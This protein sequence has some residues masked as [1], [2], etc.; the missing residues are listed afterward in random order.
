MLDLHECHCTYMNDQLRVTS[1]V[2][3]I[4]LP[5]IRQTL[6]I[7]LAQIKQTSGAQYFVL[8]LALHLI[9][10]AYKLNLTYKLHG[11]FYL[12][13]SKW[14]FTIFVKKNFKEVHTSV[15]FSYLFIKYEKFTL[16]AK[17]NFLF[18]VHSLL[19]YLK[20]SMPRV[21]KYLKTHFL[22]VKT[23]FQ[24]MDTENWKFIHIW[25]SIIFFSSL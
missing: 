11:N 17:R 25:Y 19:S 9:T 8:E 10:N 14:N 21:W 4:P 2:K 24:K 1:S 23:F 13:E 5:E 18:L 16:T 20:H 15:F 3:T 6:S 12:Y 22:K 7:K